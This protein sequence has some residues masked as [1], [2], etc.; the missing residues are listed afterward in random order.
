[1][2]DDPWQAERDTALMP[3]LM[4]SDVSR[5]MRKYFEQRARARQ[6][7]LTKA[8]CSVLFHLSRREGI[9]Q[10]AL[11]QILEVEPITLVRLLDRLEAAGLVER[12]RDKQDRRAWV[13]YLTPAAQPLIGR[14]RELITEVW[15]TVQDKMP[16][17]ERAAFVATLAT[18]KNTLVDQLSREE[19]ILE[20]VENG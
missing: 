19:T 1:M 2:S 12:R 5:L 18:L 3:A 7:G 6:L 9:N 8:Q 17:A 10:A 20:E 13:L 14:I 15:E 16:A 11:A 4:L